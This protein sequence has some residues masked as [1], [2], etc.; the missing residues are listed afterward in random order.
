[1]G[2]EVKEAGIDDKAG[3]VDD[4]VKEVDESRV[5]GGRIGT[6]GA[7]RDGT[8]KSTVVQVVAAR[9]GLLISGRAVLPG[10][11]GGNAG[12]DWELRGWDVN[13][14]RSGRIVGFSVTVGGA[15]AGLVGS[16]FRWCPGWVIDVPGGRVDDPGGNDDNTGWLGGNVDSP[17]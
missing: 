3:T 9:T 12:A 10:F 16:C 5:S 1:M 6:S 15:G 11:S 14:L 8:G 17:G 4:D 2:F 13:A 7:G